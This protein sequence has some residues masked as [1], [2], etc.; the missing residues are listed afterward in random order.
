[1][2]NSNFWGQIKDVESAN[3]A[4]NNASLLLYALAGLDI[5]IG[6]FTSLYSLIVSGV[7]LVVLAVL[8]K[9]F[10]SKWIAAVIALLCVANLVVS[11]G[12]GVWIFLLLWSAYQVWLAADFFSKQNAQV[13]QVPPSAPT[14]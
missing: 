1:M 4:V 3:K 2:A 6:Y 14:Q 9:K 13:P 5:V 7:I 11:H 12:K 10:K 8:V